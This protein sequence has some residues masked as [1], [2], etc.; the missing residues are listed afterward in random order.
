MCRS[1]NDAD[2]LAAYSDRS[3][4]RETVC[5][6]CSEA[7]RKAHISAGED[8][9]L[10]VLW[11]GTETCNDCLCISAVKPGF[12]LVPR[13]SFNLA[14]VTQ[15]HLIAKR[16]GEI[17]IIAGKLPSLVQCIKGWKVERRYKAKPAE[18][19]ERRQR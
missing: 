18:A 12:K 3:G 7:G 9:F 15:S 8:K 6:D 10:A 5:F 16:F 13:H 11:I 17:N 4:L 14:D 19:L 2:I 1:C